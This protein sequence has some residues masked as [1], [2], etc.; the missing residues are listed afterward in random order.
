MEIQ[1]ISFSLVKTILWLKSYE[2]II[3]K[4]LTIFDELTQIPSIE[5]KIIEFFYF[6]I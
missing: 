1:W 6:F 3:I 4:L 2:D 5:E